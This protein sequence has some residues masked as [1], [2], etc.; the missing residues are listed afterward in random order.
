MKETD[1]G[2]IKRDWG[3]EKEAC[4]ERWNEEED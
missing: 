2:Q 1:N 3:M 4:D